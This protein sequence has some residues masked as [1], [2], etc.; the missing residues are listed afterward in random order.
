MAGHSSVMLGWSCTDLSVLVSQLFGQALSESC[1]KMNLD[2][3]GGD[4]LTKNMLFLHV[5]KA[6][7]E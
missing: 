5:T 2:Y 1:G 7:M 3:L 4:I 6:F